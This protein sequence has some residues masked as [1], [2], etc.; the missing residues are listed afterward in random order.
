MIRLVTDYVH[1]NER[2]LS[3]RTALYVFEDNEALLNQMKKA[4]VL[5]CVTH[6]AHIVSIWIGSMT[7]TIWIQ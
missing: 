3:I 5:Q 2:F 1:Q 4:E 7:A 6:H